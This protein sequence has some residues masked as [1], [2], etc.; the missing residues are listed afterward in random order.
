MSVHVEGIEQFVRHHD[1]GLHNVVYKKLEF[2][3]KQKE[4]LGLMHV[5]ESSIVA[6]KIRIVE[7]ELE[8]DKYQEKLD[9]LRTEYLAS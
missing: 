8:L 6:W 9:E 5:R 7:A 2:E 4:L 1:D 3:R